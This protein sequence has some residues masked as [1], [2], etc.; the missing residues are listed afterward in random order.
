MG[1]GIFRSLVPGE[2]KEGMKREWKERGERGEEVDR[3]GGS[4]Q[5]GRKW[6]GG[7]GEGK[8]E[9]TNIFDAHYCVRTCIDTIWLPGGRR[10][11][12]ATCIERFPNSPI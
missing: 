2:D 10:F 8:K 6:T 3:R 12:S 11:L 1:K 7:E 5:E 4:E 9:D